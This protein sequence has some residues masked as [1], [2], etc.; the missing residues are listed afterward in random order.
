MAAILRS[1]D[2]GSRGSGRLA[3]LLGVASLLVLAFGGYVKGSQYLAWVPVDITLIAALGVIACVGQA[4]SWRPGPMRHSGWLLFL[5]IACLGGLMHQGVADNSYAASKPFA[6]FFVVPLCILGGAY[7]LQ[8]DAARHAFL[9]GIV[10]LGFVVLLLAILDPSTVAND[11]LAIDGGNTIGAGR[12]IGAA[13]AV[14]ALAVLSSR[15]WRP[16][17]LAPTALT[18]WGAIAAAS[19][20]PLLAAAVAVIAATIL[21]RSPGR[22]GRI[23]AVALLAVGAGQ[24]VFQVQS[25]NPRLRTLSD[26]SSEVRRYLWGRSWEMIQGHP[27]GVGWGRMY[28]QTGYAVLDSG[29]VQYP[30]NVILEVAGEGGW[31]AGVAFVVVLLLAVRSQLARPASPVET[32]MLALMLFAVVNSMVSGDINDG[33]P[34]WVAV[35]AALAPLVRRDASSGQDVRRGGGTRVGLSS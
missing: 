23:V 29:Y 1:M 10:L 4:L 33:R 35:G 16:F 27:L 5:L 11:R 21:G 2:K 31:V 9:S 15:R 20:G 12:A 34:L 6:V 8:T 24:Y 28:D 17:L 32:A 7:L 26:D 22:G 14:L 25:L 19:R 3:R 30:H 13:F 18:A